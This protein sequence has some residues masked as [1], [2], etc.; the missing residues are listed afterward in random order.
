MCIRGFGQANLLGH[1]GLVFSLAWL[2]PM[3]ILLSFYYQF[4]A[5][6]IIGG[7]KELEVLL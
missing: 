5:T 6:P 1:G 3:G 2:E 4:F 7:A